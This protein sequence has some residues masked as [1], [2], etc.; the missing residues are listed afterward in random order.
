MGMMNNLFSGILQIITIY[1]RY[2][3]TF[4]YKHFINLKAASIPENV[5]TVFVDFDS[6]TE[7]INMIKL[8][9]KRK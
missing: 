1:T 5:D 2:M 7:T 9:R 4:I 8:I 6:H 3:R